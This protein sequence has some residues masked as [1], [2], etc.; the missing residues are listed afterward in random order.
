ML[1]R[2]MNQW[3]KI[4]IITPSFNQGIYIE[5][6]ILSVLNQ[7]YPNIEYIIIDGGSTDN[8]IDIIKKYESKITYWVSE[9]DKGQSD[10]INKGL[11]IATGDIINWLNSDDY[12]ESNALNAIAEVF[13]KNSNINVVCGKGRQFTN[14]KTIDYTKGLDVYK[15]NIAKTIGW[16][17]MDQPETF[18]KTSVIKSIGP[19]NRSLNYLMDREWWLKYILKF[20]I[21]DIKSIDNVVVNFRLHETSKTVSQKTHFDFDHHSIFYALAAENGFDVYL[22]KIERFTKIDKNLKLN[23]SINIS[24]LDLQKSFNY[25]FLLRANICYEQNKK[26]EATFFYNN[27]DA[28]SLDP[29][30][31]I[32][33]KTMKFRNKFP[34]FI[35]KLMRKLSR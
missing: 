3:P 2:I 21:S 19:L 34:V 7:N 13:I 23:A 8:T 25:Y 18:Y 6:T 4:S 30:D 22:S 29:E 27:V 24:K 5:Q 15:N 10:A 16:L 14:D 28:K 32:L 26:V 11:K 17:R 12:Y 1:N 35:I 9:P 33:F 31:T 20:G